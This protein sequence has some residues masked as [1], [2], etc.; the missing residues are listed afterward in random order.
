MGN[1]EIDYND[2][3]RLYLVTS[4][5]NPEYLPSTFIK[6]N[7]I[8]FTITFKCLFEQFLSIVVLKERPELEDE[9]KN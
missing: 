1:M 7:L 9:R 4:L 2:S 8:N 5:S 6:V 3:F